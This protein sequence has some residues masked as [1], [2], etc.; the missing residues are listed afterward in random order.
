ML[1]QHHAALALGKLTRVTSG[2]DLPPSE[3]IMSR[4]QLTFRANFRAKMR[5]ALSSWDEHK[6][7]RNPRTSRRY[8][9][10]HRASQ[11]HARGRMLGDTLPDQWQLAGLES[12]LDDS[13]VVD[14]HPLRG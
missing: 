5:I 4:P 13:R 9:G 8:P 6:D 10:D 11:E 12:R 7:H 2:G 1:L 14:L 3:V